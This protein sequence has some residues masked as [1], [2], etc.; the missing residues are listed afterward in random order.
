M[1]VKTR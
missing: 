1:Y